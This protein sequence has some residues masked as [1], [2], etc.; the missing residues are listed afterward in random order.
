M[1]DLCIHPTTHAY[2]ELRHQISGEQCWESISSWFAVAVH[3]SL[4]FIAIHAW[5]QNLSYLL[6]WSDSS[7]IWATHINDEQLPNQPLF[8]SYWRGAIYFIVKMW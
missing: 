2:V 1:F 4:V 8:Y 5:I 7:F 3:V 6:F